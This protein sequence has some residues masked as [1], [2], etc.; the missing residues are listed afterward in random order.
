MRSRTVALRDLTRT[1]A[2]TA[3]DEAVEVPSA[4]ALVDASFVSTRQPVV[5]GGRRSDLQS[6]AIDALPPG[7]RWLVRPMTAV[8]AVAR[9]IIA[10]Q[11]I[12]GLIGVVIGAATLKGPLAAAG[13]GQLLLAGL[14]LG[15][16][17]GAERV[18]EVKDPDGEFVVRDQD[19]SR[20]QGAA[21]GADA[22][23]SGARSTG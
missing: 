4:C 17:F 15:M 6:E 18:S 20:E 1:E 5:V 9:V 16:H 2:I 22:L 19:D 8:L 23:E 14:V 7:V 11:A 13:L 12:G 21:D 3:W 10:L